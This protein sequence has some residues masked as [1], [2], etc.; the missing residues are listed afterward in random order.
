MVA[1]VDVDDNEAR[2]D[3]RAH[4]LAFFGLHLARRSAAPDDDRRACNVLE[5]RARVRCRVRGRL[6]T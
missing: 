5:G 1:S 2:V 6:R 4:L 3:A